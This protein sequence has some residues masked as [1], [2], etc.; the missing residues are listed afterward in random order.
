MAAKQPLDE[1]RSAMLEDLRSARREL[2]QIVVTPADLTFDD[3]LTL[4]H[5]AREIRVLH[6][7]RAN[8][9]G[10]ALVWLPQEKILISGDVVVHPIPYGIGSYPREWIATLNEL[11]KLPYEL[12][13]PGHGDV[14]RSQDYV[15]QLIRTLTLIREQVA[16]SVARGLDLE[17][18]T[19]ALDPSAFESA[20]T[21][22]DAVR[23]KLFT[24]WWLKRSCVP[25]GSRPAANRSFNPGSGT[26]ASHRQADLKD[27]L[28]R[29]GF[30]RKAAR[31][32]SYCRIE[33][34]F[35]ALACR[36]LSCERP[37]VLE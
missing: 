35:P 1:R 30:G 8:T 13:V 26:I 5:G 33:S 29:K 20:F 15:Q 28:R 19:R 37:G 25:P 10:D 27:G 34:R 2:D 36:R 16:V 9:D 21:N 24:A 18:T 7:G 12:L 17:A 14:Q 11:S 22:G 31:K 6:A 3:E 23:S 32:R 4:R